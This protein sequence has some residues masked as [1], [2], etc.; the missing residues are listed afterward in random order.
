MV[1]GVPT[2]TANILPEIR[3]KTQNHVQGSFTLPLLTGRA[4]Y[5]TMSMQHPDPHLNE[6]DKQQ[7]SV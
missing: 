7:H 6:F 2:L 1:E 4:G 3:K 5:A